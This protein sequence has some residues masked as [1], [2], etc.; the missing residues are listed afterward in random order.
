VIDDYQAIEGNTFSR[1][2]DADDSP[3]VNLFT[4]F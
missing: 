3:L 1:P 2:S 4:A